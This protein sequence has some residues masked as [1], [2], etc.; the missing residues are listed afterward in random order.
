M[1]IVYNTASVGGIVGGVVSFGI[2]ILFITIIIIILIIL[3]RMK[4]KTRSIHRLK[5]SLSDRTDRTGSFIGNDVELPDNNIL[6][7]AVVNI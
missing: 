4:R 7:S 6:E 3:H 1:I 2:V 5:R